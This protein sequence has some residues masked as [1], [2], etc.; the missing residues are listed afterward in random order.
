MRRRRETGS[1]PFPCRP[2]PPFR[3]ASAH[4][5]GVSWEFFVCNR[6]YRSSPA[7]V[8]HSRSCKDRSQTCR[9][10]ACF[11]CAFITASLQFPYRKY[12]FPDPE[13]FS[14]PPNLIFPPWSSPNFCQA[15][16]L[17]LPETS[18]NLPAGRLPCCAN[19]KKLS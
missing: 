8:C 16:R 4:S 15:I 9:R 1:P 3:V 14:P 5:Q 13:P 19:P 2:V 18:A 11:P 7:R 10:R 17:T 12:F 6:P